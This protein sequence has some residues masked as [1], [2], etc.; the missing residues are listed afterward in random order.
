MVKNVL[1][2]LVY[3][4]SFQK[5]VL[6]LEQSIR[7]GIFRL[8]RICR[9]DTHKVSVMLREHVIGSGLVKFANVEHILA[10]LIFNGVFRM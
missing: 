4:S 10:E 7:R 9:S 2:K 8:I 5:V 6:L 1:I 3:L